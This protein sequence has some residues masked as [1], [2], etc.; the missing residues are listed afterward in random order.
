[1]GDGAPMG[2]LNKIAATLMVG[3]SILVFV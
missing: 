1:L 3:V 2:V